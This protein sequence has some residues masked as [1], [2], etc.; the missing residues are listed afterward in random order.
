MEQVEHAPLGD[1]GPIQVAVAKRARSATRRLPRWLVPSLILHFLFLVG[2]ILAARTLIGS[3]EQLAMGTAA[4]HDGIR[5]ND[6]T[7]GTLSAETQKLRSEIEGLRNSLLSNSSEDVIFLKITILKRDIDPDLARTIARSVRRYSALYGKDPNLVLAIIDV[8]SRFDPKATS[9]VGALGL[10]QV[11]PQWQKILG[12][13]GDLTDPDVSIKYGMQI[14]GFY[15]EMYRDVE[16]AL[17]AYNRGPGPVDHAFM[18]GKDPRNG[19]AAKVLGVYERLKRF[20]VS[21]TGSI[22]S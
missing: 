19:Y 16:M 14:L 15:E 18:K 3:I 13:E 6:K 8:E 21:A 12:I 17:T 4:N 22:D 10:M 9:H 7:I 20:S 11:M 5:E 1:T 2:V